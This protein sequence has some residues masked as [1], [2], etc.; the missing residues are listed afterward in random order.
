MILLVAAVLVSSIARYTP[1]GHY[2]YA[3][4][5]TSRRPLLRH[6]DSRN[7]ILV[8]GLMT[9][10]SAV[11]GIITISELSSAAPDIGDLK[12]LEAIAACVIEEPA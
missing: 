11:C 1:F 4:G 2:V 8:F 3:I 10:L 6:F 9:M 7:T 12:E 5:V